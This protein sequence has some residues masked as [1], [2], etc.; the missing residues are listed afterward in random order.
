MSLLDDLRNQAEGQRVAEQEDAA[1]SG[2]RE[3]Y[4]SE[5]MLPR[6]VKA[7]QFFKE[8]TEH[9]NYIKLDTMVEYPLYA[10]GGTHPMRQEGYAVLIDSSK[11]LKQIDVTFQCVLDD[12]ISFWYWVSVFAKP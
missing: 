6:M 3:Q 12:P 4:Y 7:Y 11:E 10:N 5:Q 1:R 9:L 8:L 2:Q